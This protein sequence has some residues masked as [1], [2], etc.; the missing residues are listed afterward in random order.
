[1]HRALGKLPPRNDPRTFKL[2][3][4]LGKG[5]A[6]IPSYQAPPPAR[7]WVDHQHAFDVL[8]NDHIGN[9]AFVAQAHLIQCHAA[10]NGRTALI[11]RTAVLEAYRRV[12]DYD[13]EDPTTDRGTV[14]LDALTDWRKIG[15]GGHRILAYMRVEPNRR[16]VESAINLFGGIYIGAGLPL[17]AQKQT[18]W[19][20][21]PPNH[22][23]SSNRPNSWGGHAFACPAYNRTGLVFVTWGALK[24]ATWEWLYTYADEIYAVISNDWVAEG[25]LSPSGFDLDKLRQDLAAVTSTPA[26]TFR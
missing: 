24:I 6:G 20:V 3:S 5:G 21:A 18:V 11:D 17:A 4:Y 22:Y 25:Q 10:A 9:C 26:P 14:L 8:G 13:P 7:D 1:M 2:A 15:I 16:E 19:D 23:E 12:T